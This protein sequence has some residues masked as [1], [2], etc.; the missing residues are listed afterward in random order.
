M[1]SRT[2]NK[3]AG[4][5]DISL[6]IYLIANCSTFGFLNIF[7]PR[8][9]SFPESN[10]QC[11]VDKRLQPFLIV[12]CWWLNPWSWIPWTSMAP[13]VACRTNFRLR[14]CSG[15]NEALET[16]TKVFVMAIT[17]SKWLVVVLWDNS[18]CPKAAWN[19]NFYFLKTFWTKLLAF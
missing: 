3:Q 1:N 11:K 4:Q 19:G 15:M 2:G 10:K 17:E 18:Q 8:W 16:D 6:K 7:D 9:R 5:L 13:W 12:S 14:S